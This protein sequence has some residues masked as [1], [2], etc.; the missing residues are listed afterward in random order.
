MAPVFSAD[1]GCDYYL[2]AGTW[3]HLLTG[4]L[5]AGPGWHRESYGF[6]SLPLFV[7]PGAVLPRGHRVDRPDT[8]HH[9]GLTLEVYRPTEMS[10][11]VITVPGTRG[12]AT[13]TVR[14]HD[15]ELTVTAVGIDQPWQVRVVGTDRSAGAVGAGVV[16]VR[17]G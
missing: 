2:P 6:D 15:G 1:G 12:P 8:D 16:T 11:Q 3:T 9:D 13:F 4:E 10:D 7:R 5:R 14:C 17:L